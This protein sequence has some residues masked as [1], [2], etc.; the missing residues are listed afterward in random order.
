MGTLYRN[1]AV[2]A[3]DLTKWVPM[4]SA[5]KPSSSSP[6]ALTANLNSF[7]NI[8]RVIC[9]NFPS[10]MTVQIGVSRSIPGIF[11]ILS[12]KAAAALTGQTT[13]SP[14]ASCVFLSILSPFF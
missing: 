10:C 7:S 3:A 2:A 1:I 11:C 9:L 5:L 4:S 14:V 13:G 8:S 12:T 6:I